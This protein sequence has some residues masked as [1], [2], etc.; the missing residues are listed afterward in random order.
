MEDLWDVLASLAKLV[1]FLPSERP[2]LQKW[3][4]EGDTCC[5]TLAS[6]CKYTYVHHTHVHRLSP[7]HSALEFPCLFSLMGGGLFWMLPAG[8]GRSRGPQVNPW[9]RFCPGAVLLLMDCLYGPLSW[10]GSRAARMQA[11]VGFL[12]P[13]SDVPKVDTSVLNLDLTC[14]SFLTVHW[15]Q[16]SES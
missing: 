14:G 5:R 9:T 7:H 4:L 13:S 11:Q 10:V 12:T 16:S 6:K 8:K 2:C 3:G 1:S 15:F